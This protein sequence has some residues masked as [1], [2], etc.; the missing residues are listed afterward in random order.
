MYLHTIA[1]RLTP[2]PLNRVVL[3]VVPLCSVLWNDTHR[4][5]PPSS[6]SYT[7]QQSIT[8]HSQQTTP[9]PPAARINQRP[10]DP[11]PN[12]RLSPPSPPNTNFK[13]PQID[14]VE[15]PVRSAKILAHRVTSR[16]EAHPTIT[17]L[18]PSPYSL[19]FPPTT[20]FAFAHTQTHP[21]PQ[22]AP[23]CIIA[24]NSSLLLI[25][26]RQS[27]PVTDLYPTLA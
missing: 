17:S 25:P 9:S 3:H 27:F 11:N 7:T 15:T 14:N 1:I 21:P 6:S 5:P 18:P 16:E 20:L 22:A 4:P 19:T 23:D 10:P 24:E 8:P 2:T 26:T 12:T 13:T